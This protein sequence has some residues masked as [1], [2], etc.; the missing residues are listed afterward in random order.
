M[1]VLMIGGVSFMGLAATRQLLASGH[2]V[3]VYHR[4]NSEPEEARAAMHFHGE[5]DDLVSAR[6]EL[7]AFKPDVA[8]HMITMTEAQAA[9]FVQALSGVAA[10]AVVISSQDVYRAYG[11]VLGKEPG[12]PDPTPLSEEAPLR[13]RLYPYRGDEPRAAEDPVRWMDEYDKILVERVVMSAP[14]LPCAVLRMPAVYGPRDRQ[15][16]FR[17]WLKRMDDGRPAILMDEAEARWRWTHGYVEDVGRAIALAALDA[18]SAGRI[19]NVGERDARS[20]E[21]RAQAVAEAA[22][23]RGRIALAPAGMLPEALRAGVVTTQDLVTDSARIRTELGYAEVTPEADS[24]T[25]AVAWERENPPEADDPADYDY[26]AE[27][28]ALASLI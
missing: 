5:R 4:G 28:R 16:R 15:R 13:E 2:D 3:A 11:R 6:S 25:R 20:L 21:E 14:D 9:D 26:D 17:R 19:Y 18:R 12:T 7:A 1:R 10:R 22:G 8:V 27:D 24:Y 23:W